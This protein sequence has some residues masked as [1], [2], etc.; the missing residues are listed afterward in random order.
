MKGLSPAYFISLTSICASLYAISIILTAYLP[1]PWGVGHLRLGIIIPAIFALLGGPWVAGIGAAIGSFLG[2]IFG[3]VPFGRT[4]PILALFAGVPANFVGFF[5]FGYLIKKYGNWGSFLLI[6]FIALLIGNFIAALNVV[7]YIG[8][9]FPLNHPWATFSG[10]LLHESLNLKVGLILGFLLFWL[11]TMLPVMLFAFPP[12]VKALSPLLRRYP[13][14]S[15]LVLEE[16]RIIVPKG[17][18]LGIILLAIAFILYFT[19]IIQVVPFERIMQN[20]DV[21]FGITYLFLLTFGT[22]LIVIFVPFLISALK[23]SKQIK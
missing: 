9:L 23:Y 6:S 18:I 20:I 15:K 5:I 19:P 14:V 8:F 22:G 7:I 13:Y 10:V 12:L 11:L 1:T 4:D 3:L 2:D 17:F 16:P 21:K